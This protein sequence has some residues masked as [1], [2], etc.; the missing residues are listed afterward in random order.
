VHTC[1]SSPWKNEV[2]GFQVQTSL[3]YIARPCLKKKDKKKTPKK[4]KWR[5]EQRN[6][7][8]Q[9]T[10]QTNKQTNKI[11]GSGTIEFQS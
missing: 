10:E 7:N 9:E 6:R 4:S 2:E 1:N 5:D 3:S 11:S 8:K